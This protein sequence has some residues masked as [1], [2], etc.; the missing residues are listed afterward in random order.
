MAIINNDTSLIPNT[1]INVP[2][3]DRDIFID[4]IMN[5]LKNYKDE[6]EYCYTFA[7]MNDAFIFDGNVNISDELSEFITDN[8]CLD[9]ENAFVTSGEY[10]Q[11]IFDSILGVRSTNN[12]VVFWG[13]LINGD[14]ELPAI[15]IIYFD[16]TNFKSYVPHYGNSI[17]WNN[18]SAFGNYV[19]EDD[20][21]LSQ[22]NLNYLDLRKCST[23]DLIDASMIMQELDT[24]FQ[25]QGSYNGTIINNSKQNN[26]N[27]NI[28]SNNTNNSS[29][30]T[31]QTMSDVL[32]QIFEQRSY[33]LIPA[34]QQSILN[35]GFQ[36]Y[37]KSLC[38]KNIKDK[39]TML[40]DIYNYIV[41]FDNNGDNA[42]KTIECQ[43][44]ITYIKKYKYHHEGY[45]Y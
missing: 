18:N 39:D 25:L 14:W 13:T 12:G 6:D 4:G 17:N 8:V 30:Q 32:L 28:S 7:E 41:L 19:D 45:L 20:D 1:K 2:S 31:K 16:G 21:Y 29:N 42:Y 15:R 3:I 33:T 38:F 22:Y 40:K 44:L 5:M 36:S 26:N 10:N 9:M 23:S 37:D 34:L 43:K 35:Q 11:R 24:V 27:G